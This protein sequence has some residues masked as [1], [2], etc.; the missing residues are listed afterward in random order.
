VAHRRDGRFVVFRL[1]AEADVVADWAVTWQRG[2]A[3]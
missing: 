1:D 3:R 2:S